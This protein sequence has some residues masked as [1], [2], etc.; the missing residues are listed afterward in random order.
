MFYNIDEFLSHLNEEDVV[1]AAHTYQIYSYFI[2]IKMGKEF[3]LFRLEQNTMLLE[4]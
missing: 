2:K 3:Q 4:F 1:I